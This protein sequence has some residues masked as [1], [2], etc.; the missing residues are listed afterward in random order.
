MKIGNVFQKSL[1]SK[2]ALPERPETRG[3]R[4]EARDQRPEAGK[5]AVMV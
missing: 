1:Y 4:P 5:T 2:P 3:Q